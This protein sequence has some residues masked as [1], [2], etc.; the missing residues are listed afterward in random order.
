[1]HLHVDITN[2]DTTVARL[3]SGVPVPPSVRDRLLC[4]ATVQPVWVR[5]HVPIGVGRP[6][7]VIPERT[8]RIVV[9]RDLGQCRVPGCGRSRVEIHHIEHRAQR[10]VTETWNLLS[11]C[12][13]HHRLHHLGQLGI[14]G[15]AD[16]PE[17]LEFTD[18]TG[19]RL[20]GCGMPAPPPSELIGPAVGYV[21]PTGER[22]VRHW[23]T[24]DP[25][26]G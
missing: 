5:D 26:P 17:T 13:R 3:T 7:P 11:L 19:R 8:R 2:P 18:P 16:R 22:L 25:R 21:H 20:L 4:D 9:H 10:G 15:N 1:M 6:T 12:G 14:T 23:V 24:L